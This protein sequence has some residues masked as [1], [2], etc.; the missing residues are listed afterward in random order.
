MPTDVCRSVPQTGTDRAQLSSDLV[1]RYVGQE[2]FGL[3]SDLQC[4]S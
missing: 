1:D 4:Q 3:D 2:L